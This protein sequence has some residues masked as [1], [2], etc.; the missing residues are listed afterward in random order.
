MVALILHDIYTTRGIWWDTTLFNRVA[1]PQGIVATDLKAKN[2]V[3]EN[4]RFTSAGKITILV[5]PFLREPQQWRVRWRL[6][7]EHNEKPC[8]SWALEYI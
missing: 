1:L 8:G 5:T 7:S 2:V 6:S 3:K 4:N